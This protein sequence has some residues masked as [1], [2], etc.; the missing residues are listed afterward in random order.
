MSPVG[1]AMGT[2][3]R[4]DAV[5]MHKAIYE[6]GAALEQAR[7][8]RV[9]RPV[10]HPRYVLLAFAVLGRLSRSTVRAETDLLHPGQWRHV[11]QVMRNAMQLHGLDL[12]DPGPTPP[13]R[14]HWRR[15]RDDFLTTDE[16][17]AAFH[18]AYVPA[19]LRLARDIGLLLPNGPGSLT[20]PDKSRVLY[21][22]GTIVRP[23]YAPPE[24]IRTELPDGT[25]QIAYP[26]KV[27]GE[28]LTAPVGR[29]D[30]DIALFHGH[31]GPVLGHG[32]VSISARG[33]KPYQRVMLAS[34]HIPA[35]GQEAATAVAMLQ[36]LH[37]HVGEGAHAVIWD[38]AMRG[39]HIDAIMRRCGWIVIA[40]TYKATEP[41]KDAPTA[42]RLPDGKTARGI[43]LDTISHEVNGRTCT[44]QLAAINGRAV[45][46]DLDDQGDPVIVSELA[47]GAVK[48]QR[49]RDGRYHLN[50]GLTVPCPH[51][52]VTIWL[53]PHADR[54]HPHRPEHLRVIPEHD[55]D[56]VR[57]RGLRS[58]AESTW[59]ML[60]STLI[61]DRAM[62]LGWRRGLIDLHAFSLLSNA[63]TEHRARI[64]ANV[65]SERRMLRVVR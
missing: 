28:L 14:H 59:R 33:P 26:D 11:R 27:T 17:L 50:V 61:A 3:E 32:Y 44:H 23:I 43:P 55:D 38:G 35:P 46:I 45:E 53:S 5:L 42:V 2:Q 21:G 8:R 41:S 12:P 36:D 58:D 65:A 9:G 1:R 15:W 6:I 49:R 30:P 4:L 63:L 13:Q 52:A 47:R 34:A 57:I 40:P 37:R 10:S 22:D 20:H 29:F 62:S 18:E 64:A 24:A 16:G 60:K 7:D 31:R 25:I 51:E 48:R 19:A 56:W 54:T 39:V